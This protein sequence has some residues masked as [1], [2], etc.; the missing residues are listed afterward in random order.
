MITRRLLFLNGVAVLGVILNHAAA[1]GFVAMFWWAHRYL[2]VT[3]PDFSQLGGTAYYGLRFVE[4]L[5]SFSIPAFLLVSG[6]FVAFSGRGAPGRINAHFAWDRIRQFVPPY[7]IWSIIT[8]LF[9]VSL[10]GAAY[11]LA[12]VG[13]MLL[14]GQATPAFYFVPLLVQLYIL[15]PLLIRWASRSWPSLLG[16]AAAV[17]IIAHIVRYLRIL[18]LSGSSEALSRLL[19]SGWFFPANVFW[20]ALGITIGL[21]LNR[22]GE[23]LHRVRWVMLVL[24]VL[25]LPAGMIEWEALMRASGQ[26][27]ITPTETLVDNLYSLAVLLGFLGFTTLPA[28]LSRRIGDLGGKSYGI[29]LV[30]SI[31]L[32]LAARAVYHLAPALLG[33]QFG[34]QVVLVAAGLAGPLALMYLVRRSP[35]RRL[36]PLLFG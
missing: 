16:V 14:L 15:S 29:Y 8:I 13:R 4:Q 25:L 12:D 31:V 22:I 3:S 1:W 21:N 5:I 32:I 23:T 30:H 11:R 20:F 2:P 24:A 34:F 10:Q 35:F 27:W 17:Q 28:G 26:V 6:L 33:W 7:L 19:G 36:Y 9:D 18:E